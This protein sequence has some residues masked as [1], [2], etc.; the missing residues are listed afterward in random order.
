[1][2]LISSAENIQWWPTKV[3]YTKQCSPYTLN[4]TCTQILNLWVKWPARPLNFRNISSY[5]RA[6]EFAHITMKI[7][8]AVL[9]EIKSTAA[10]FQAQISCLKV[11]ITNQNDWKNVCL[12][13]S[14]ARKWP[15][16]C[17]ATVGVLHKPCQHTALISADVMDR[18]RQ[19][20]LQGTCCWSWWERNR[21]C[22]EEMELSITD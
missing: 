6:N 9:L 10:P 1:M 11:D 14:R 21:G 19:C 17:I 4:L 8:N 7:N 15:W 20:G 16:T 22:V 13:Y 2:I 5:F 12:W 3:N 18:R